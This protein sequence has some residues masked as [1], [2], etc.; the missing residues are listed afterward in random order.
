M[1]VT[2]P[3]PDD[4]AARF[5]SGADLGRRA[6]EALVL[7]EFRT[8]RMTQPELQA[9]LGLSAQPELGNFLRAYGLAGGMAAADAD[10]PARDGAAIDLVA[11]FR[12]FRADKTLGD[13]E[14]GDLIREG[15][16]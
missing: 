8:G 3:I 7:E 9:V 12:A 15:R 10:Q 13:L 11:Q 16:R 14:I 1:N 5:G 6:L 2:I 4:F